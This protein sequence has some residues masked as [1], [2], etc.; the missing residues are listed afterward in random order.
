MDNTFKQK[1]K[2]LG[3]YMLAGLFI[4]FLWAA[5]PAIADRTSE[6]WLNDGSSLTPNPSSLTL[7]ASSSP[8]GFGHFDILSTGRIIATSTNATSTFANGIDITGGCLKIGGSCISGGTTYTGTYPVQVSG[9]AISLAFG[10]TTTNTWSNAQTFTT[11]PVLATLSG[12]IGGNSGQTY[13]VSTS[14]ITLGNLTLG[15]ALSRANGGTGTTTWQTGSVVFA[16]AT[17]QTED[18]TNLYWDDTNNRLGIGGTTT[19]QR[20]LSVSGPMVSAECNLTDGATVTF[21]LALC[22]QGK[23][24]LG[25][26]RALDFTNETQALGQGVRVVVCQ[27]GTGSRTLTHDSAVRWAGG[28]APTLT[29]TAN[30][31]DVLAGF[32]SI[33]TGTPIIMLDKVLSF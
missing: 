1:L 28:T 30:K 5:G 10:T 27:D 11:A 12:L 31:C 4:S 6:W 14:T 7:G 22:N 29:T 13:A 32:T 17:Y 3:K 20:T 33:A 21:N 9:S 18:N 26:N 2:T 19:P 23:V 25:G 15:T 8:I 24:V 16:G